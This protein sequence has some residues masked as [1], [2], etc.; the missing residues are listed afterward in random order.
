MQPGN[1]VKVAGVQVGTV[2]DI[3]IDHGM[4][5]VVMSVD[6]E[7]LPLHADATAKITLESLLG[8]RYV[9]LDRGTP[10]APLLGE[11]A[12]IPGAQTNRDV[13]LQEVLNAA[14]TPTSVALAG[15]ITTTGQ[16]LHGNGAKFASAIS[17][18]EPALHQTDQLVGILNQ[19]NAQLNRLVEDAAPVANAVAA[20]QGQRLDKMVG[21]T[22]ETLSVVAARQQA[23]RDTLQQLPGS[24]ASARRTLAQLAGVADPTADTLAA[25]RP[26]TDNL[27]DISGELRRFS[28][29]A[30]PALASLPPVLDRAQE[31]LDQARPVAESLRGASTNLR[32]TSDG[33]HGLVSNFLD[34]R[35]SDLMELLKGW[36]LA[37]ADYDAIS[38]YFKAEVVTD[39]KS[40]GE[41][42]AA[43]VPGVPPAPVPGGLPMPS[44][45]MPRLDQVGKPVTPPHSTERPKQGPNAGATGLTPN[46]EDSMMSQLLGGS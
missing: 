3:T 26:T 6:R 31:L 42:A 5:K 12:N 8:E 44:P 2:S 10:K 34:L 46:Q 37:T 15:L 13:D 27:K 19:Q 4:A 22:T 32:G 25:I 24:L 17:A 28:D 40:D 39:P 23:L 20:D 33:L 21:S 45:L 29:A 16:G 14:D 30:D 41:L 36:S 35:F 11:P 43:P 9:A 38:H 7:A 1:V 18:L